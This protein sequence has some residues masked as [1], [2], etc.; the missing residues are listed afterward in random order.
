MKHFR[1]IWDEEKNN[2]LLEN[3]NLPRSQVYQEFMKKWPDSEVSFDA[4]ND[5]R[6][7]IGACQKRKKNWSTKHKNVGSE[8]QKKNYIRIKV[9]ELNVWMFKHHYV[10][11]INTGY[12]P[13]SKKETIIFL[14]GNNRNFNFE[15]LYLISRKI[16]A[17]LNNPNLKLGVV[18]GNPEATKINIETAK[19]I[20]KTFEIGKKIGLVN[21]A[22]RFK[23]DANEYAK[24]NYNKKRIHERT[25]R[26]WQK[27]KKDPERLALLH[28]KRREWYKKNR[29]RLIAKRME[30]YRK[31]GK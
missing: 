11:L 30:Y 15:N 14:D 20:H 31:N 7:R 5:H 21:S 3:K 18:P 6:S 22:G 25:V 2:F 23:K 10:W 27:I 26:H 8:Q 19:L 28:Q 4:F 24:K 17:I 13:D 9:A 12:K 16:I 29:E 1:K